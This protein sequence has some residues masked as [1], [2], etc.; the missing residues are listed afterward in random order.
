MSLR[1]V[2]L[3]GVLVGVGCFG[4]ATSLHPGGYDWSRDYLST[5]LR[6]ASCPARTLAIAG[7]LLFSA[8][9]GLVFERL[10]RAAESSR[11]AKVIRIG[12]IGSMVY[13]SLAITPMHDLMVTIALLFFVTG[14]LALLQALS[15]SREIWFLVAGFGSLGLLIVS[16]AIY[17]TDQYV[18]LLPWAQRLSFTSCAAW[19]VSLDLRLPRLRL[20][21]SEPA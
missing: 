4:G 17:Y 19:L 11:T 16:A 12:G 15:A 10:A 5:L 20:G 14:V 9:I 1:W 2:P 7:L 18:F 21:K 6:A 8:S 13:A 3:I